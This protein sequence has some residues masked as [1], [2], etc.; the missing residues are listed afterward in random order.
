[1]FDQTIV[2][3]RKPQGPL[4]VRLGDHWAT[5]LKAHESVIT[6]R[7]SRIAL[8]TI[9]V[10]GNPDRTITFDPQ[11]ETQKAG[12]DLIMGFLHTSEQHVSKFEAQREARK[13]AKANAAFIAKLQKD[14]VIT[15]RQS[16]I[17]LRTILGI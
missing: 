8:R 7:Q 14:C 3:Q 4:Q 6:N 11:D 2:L 5:K 17:A 1:V 15:N 16:R 10:R 13:V 12:Y 9:G